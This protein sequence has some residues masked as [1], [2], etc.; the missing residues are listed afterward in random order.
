MKLP[1]TFGSLIDLIFQIL[2]LTP[3]C[4]LK[5]YFVLFYTKQYKTVNQNPNFLLDRSRLTYMQNH[6]IKLYTML[7]LRIDLIFRILILTTF[8][9]QKRYFLLFY[10]KQPK[11]VKK[12]PNFLL[13]RSRLTYMQNHIRKLDTMLGLRIDLIFWILILTTF[14]NQKRYSLL[15]YTKQPKTVRKIQIFFQIDPG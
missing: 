12:I 14:C 15:F 9:N 11:T 8:C 10:T 13:D 4:N 5:L 6:T 2:I 3:F 7:G 1:T